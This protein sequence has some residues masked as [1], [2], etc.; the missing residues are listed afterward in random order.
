MIDEKILATFTTSSCSLFEAAYFQ[1]LSH[2]KECEI[3]KLDENHA[4]AK[5][6]S[7]VMYWRILAYFQLD[8]LKQFSKLSGL[9]FFVTDVPPGPQT[10]QTANGGRV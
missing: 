5:R 6:K 2:L 1:F 3:L 9:S 4:P 8:E 10:G 7:D